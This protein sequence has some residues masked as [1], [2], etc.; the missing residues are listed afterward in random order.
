MR[1]YQFITP[2]VT[3]YLI[4]MTIPLPRA[5]FVTDSSVCVTISTTTTLIVTEYLIYMTIHPSRVE[6]VTILPVSMTISLLR[7]TI[8]T[9]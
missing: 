5:A 8:V 9:V 6:N 7:A 4:Y 3:E 2:I 1:E